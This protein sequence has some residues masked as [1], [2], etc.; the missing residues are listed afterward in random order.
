MPKN[1]FFEGTKKNFLCK[2][3]FGTFCTC[4]KVACAKKNTGANRDITII[5]TFDLS[6]NSY[7]PWSITTFW[8]L[9]LFYSAIFSL[10]LG[11]KFTESDSSAT[12]DKKLKFLKIHN[13]WT[14][15]ARR[16]LFFNGRQIKKVFDYEYKRYL[17]IAEVLDAKNSV[18]TGFGT[19]LCK[20]NSDEQSTWFKHQ[21]LPVGFP[22]WW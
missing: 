9:I 8:L 17:T 21:P 18:F 11:S 20:E 19:Y 22:W 1:T 2:K 16:L 4:T 14:L 7:F 10:Q 15:I 5:D 12:S 3:F 13:F 6:S